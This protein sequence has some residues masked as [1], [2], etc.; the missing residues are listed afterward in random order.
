MSVRVQGPGRRA[1]GAVEGARGQAA[2]GIKDDKGRGKGDDALGPV[3]RLRTDPVDRAR[4]EARRP[5]RL[6]QREA[7]SAGQDHQRPR[8]LARGAGDGVAKGGVGRGP[9]RAED[10]RR[11]ARHTR[12]DATECPRSV[13]HEK[14]GA[15]AS[16]T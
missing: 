5:Q 3:E 16:H 1:R 13:H 14:K 7:P 11:R 4:Q 12:R 8:D 2:D 10:D 9:G 15:C 6:Q